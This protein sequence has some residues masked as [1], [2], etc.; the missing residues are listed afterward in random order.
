MVNDYDQYAASRQ[1][2]FKYGESIPHRFVEKPAMRSVL[3]DLTGK[4]VLLLGCGSGEE[5]K[6]LEEFGGAGLVGIDLSAESIRLAQESYPEHEFTVGDMHKLPFAN[7]V[8]DFVYSSLTV[9]YSDNPLSVYKEVSRVL[10]PGGSFQ[11]SVGHPMRW[12]SDVTDVNGRQVRLLGYSEGK[13]KPQLYGK[14]HSFSRHQATF[15][16]GMVIQYW[17]GPPSMHFNLLK[18]AGFTVEE[19]LETRAIEECKDVDP[20]YYERFREFPQWAVFVAKKTMIAA[21]C[22]CLN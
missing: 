7:E 18:Q 6:L 15:S 10:K 9:H 11:F 1:Q 4:R 14:Y 3:P 13:N 12:A 8:Y 17:I 2:K 16:D 21:D 22:D 20:Y 19:F 5:S